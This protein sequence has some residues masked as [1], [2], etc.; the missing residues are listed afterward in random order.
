MRSRSE[1]AKTPSAEEQEIANAVIR[2]YMEKGLI[3]LEPLKPGL[4]LK[5][6]E[7]NIYCTDINAAHDISSDKTEHRDQMMNSNRAN[8]FRINIDNDNNFTT[9]VVKALC[10]IEEN[11]ERVYIDYLKKDDAFLQKLLDNDRVDTFSTAYDENLNKF[12]RRWESINPVKCAKTELMN[13]QSVTFELDGNPKKI[14]KD[15]QKNKLAKNNFVDVLDHYGKLKKGEI[16]FNQSKTGVTIKKPYISKLFIDY[17]E[18]KANE[19]QQ[20]PPSFYDKVLDVFG[21]N[22]TKLMTAKSEQSDDRT[23][24]SEDTATR[25]PDEN[26]KL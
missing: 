15:F 1:H 14:I 9:D 25:K 19:K 6:K 22:K 5:D 20:K 4:F 10:F 23:I 21:M 2:I 3:I 24:E 11:A 8:K 12:N 13:M 17:L 16:V 7:G 26:F 18:A